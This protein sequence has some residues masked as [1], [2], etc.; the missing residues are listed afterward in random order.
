MWWWEMVNKGVCVWQNKITRQCG[1]C[2][3]VA[4]MCVYGSGS[5]G[6]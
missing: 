6:R 5:K 4:A 1:T 2:V 3:Y